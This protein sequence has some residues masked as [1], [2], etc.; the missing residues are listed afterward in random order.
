MLFA[1]VHHI[2][3]L[4]G[5]QRVMEGVA[6][7]PQIGAKEH[8]KASSLWEA[9][10]GLTVIDTGK[11]IGSVCGRYAENECCVLTKLGERK[12]KRRR[13]ESEWA[14]VEDAFDIAHSLK[15]KIVTR[16]DRESRKLHIYRVK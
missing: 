13:R 5:F 10:A 4:A 12:L 15:I 7:Y 3:D 14:D 6:V 8:W 2:H 1:A 9:S 11:L 16:Y